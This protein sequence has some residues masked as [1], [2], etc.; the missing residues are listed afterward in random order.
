M[1]NPI[2]PHPLA[3]SFTGVKYFR[4]ASPENGAPL[5]RKNPFGENPILP[6]NDNTDSS[7]LV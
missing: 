5:D 3:E 4:C 2:H 6:T 1:Q 7:T